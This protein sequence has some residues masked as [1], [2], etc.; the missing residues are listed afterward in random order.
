VEL[1]RI[2]EDAAPHLLMQQRINEYMRDKVTS[3]VCS[4]DS[5]T[6]V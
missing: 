5:L 2:F 3:L 4:Q 1:T 6:T